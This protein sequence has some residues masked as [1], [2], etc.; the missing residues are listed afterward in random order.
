MAMTI[1]DASTVI[2]LAAIGCLALL[3]QLE[4]PCG[5]ATGFPYPLSL[6]G[7]GRGEVK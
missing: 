3:I 7:E 1:A 2:H 5:L 6:I 4:I